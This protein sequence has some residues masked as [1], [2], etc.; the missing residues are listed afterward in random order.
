MKV[1]VTESGTIEL[2][3]ESYAKLRRIAEDREITVRELIETM[4]QDK[5]EENET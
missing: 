3:H 2:D 1:S 4:L 5:L